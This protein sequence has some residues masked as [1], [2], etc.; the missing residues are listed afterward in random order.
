MLREGQQVQH[1]RVVVLTDPMADRAVL[2]LQEVPN[3]SS[4]THRITSN[5]PLEPCLPQIP[6]PRLSDDP[7][8]RAL[9]SVDDTAESGPARHFVWSGGEVRQTN[10]DAHREPWVCG[11]CG[12]QVL[13]MNSGE[14]REHMIC[15]KEVNQCKF[16]ETPL[17]ALCGDVMQ[18]RVECDIMDALN[19]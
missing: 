19:L 7:Q 13:P 10:Y 8:L 12:L 15:K 4:P 9:Q 17:K 6:L 11:E 3:P 16:C 18:G 2:E 14:Q 5:Q 1:A